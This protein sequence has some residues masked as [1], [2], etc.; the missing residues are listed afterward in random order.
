MFTQPEFRDFRGS[1]DAQIKDSKP[2]GLGNAKRQAEPI[3]AEEEN[4]MW[5][6][7]V[8]GTHS[9]QA[10]ADTM[11]FLIGMCFGLRGGQEH[12]QLHWHNS[13]LSLV[14]IPADS[15]IPL[16]RS[17]LK[18]IEDVSKNNQGGI[19]MRKIEPKT[20]VQH[21]NVENPH[22][23][24]V[25]VFKEYDKRC[26]TSRPGN[27]F[28]LQPLK[29]PK[30]DV[31]FSNVPI[32][33]NS[34]DKTIGR[35]CKTAGIQGFKTNHS[36]RV[37]LATRLFQNGIDEQLIMTKTGHRSTDGVRKYKR[38]GNDQLQMLSQ[39]A[40]GQVPQTQTKQD[41]LQD[42]NVQV[43]DHC[44]ASQLGKLQR[45]FPNWTGKHTFSS[46]SVFQLLNHY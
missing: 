42:S 5:K 19:K 21:E 17:Y 14:E 31:W 15:K 28:Y 37:S 35:M 30:D 36:L 2:K 45:I 12:R 25:R 6:C 4:I 27:S 18:Y 20:V 22:R 44:A 29:D 8:L 7:G 32:G 38:V 33:H 10:L 23:C 24:I 3:T 40:Q 11:F 26:S 39:V 16:Q 13:Q 9:P 46:F 43:Q 34:L 41:V 1:L